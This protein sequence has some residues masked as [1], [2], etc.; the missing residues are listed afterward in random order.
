MQRMNS[1]PD[2]I[3][4]RLLEDGLVAIIRGDFSKSDYQR[5][6]ESLM[7]GGI[8]ALEITLNSTDALTAIR[9]LR[10]DF[11]DLLIG[12][13]T[14]RDVAG[15]QAATD[16]GAMFL[17]APNLNL[18]A[19]KTA[20]ELNTLIIPGIFTATEAHQAQ[21]AGCQLV[22]L[23]PA[24][25]VGPGYLKALRAPLSDIDFMPTGGVTPETLA[26]FYQ[27]GAVAFGIGSY[28]VKQVTMTESEA[29]AL[30][31]RTRQLRD[32]LSRLRG[33]RDSQ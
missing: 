18:E 9:T 33:S 17:I 22:K 25:Q 32:E 12:A 10:H 1:Q 21:A 30:T 2:D 23:F 27:A 7:A 4:K 31:G 5:I 26:A 15:V 20:S 19:V 28:L 16:A 3:R 13:G 6:A 8:H 14:V 24:D 29:Q 11:P